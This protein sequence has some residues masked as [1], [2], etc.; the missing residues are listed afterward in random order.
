MALNSQRSD[1][2]SSVRTTEAEYRLLVSSIKAEIS[3]KPPSKCFIYK[4]PAKLCTRRDADAYTYVPRVISIGPYHH[5]GDAFK[6]SEEH[7]RCYLQDLVNRS[8]TSI[9]DFVKSIIDVED[10]VRDC[11]EES[12]KGWRSDKFVKMMVFDGCF[13]LELLYKFKDQKKESDGVVSVDRNCNI[14]DNTYRDGELKTPPNHI[15]DPVLGSTWRIY[16]IRKDLVLLENQLPFIVLEKLFELTKSSSPDN[17]S[18]DK[19][20]TTFFSPI[21]P[22]VQEVK[23]ES[24]INGNHILDLLRNH[25][26]PQSPPERVGD[27]AL[28]EHT[29]SA[30]DLKNAGVK[31]KKKDSNGGLLD[32]TFASPTCG[33]WWR[34]C[35]MGTLEIPPFAF[36]ESWTVL[37]P[38]LIA[39]E[40][41]RRDYTDQITSYVILMDSLINSGN[42]VKILR[43]KRIIDRLFHEDDKVAIDI[44]NLSKG[45]V[46]DRFYY[47]F[48]CSEVNAYC[49][50]RRHRWR[51]NLMRDY[52]NTPWS[53]IKFLAAVIL[54]GLTAIQTAYSIKSYLPH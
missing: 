6:L 50:K 19:L 46:A 38:N 26:L 14:N 41:C 4:V 49:R 28:W 31:F 22:Y 16:S 9:D 27:Y 21:L 45:V 36:G 7:K 13:I 30:T 33:G 24:Q 15:S 48:L 51:A 8:S 54:L 35:T 43:R 44:S 18:L 3:P 37:F 23:T 1:I 5:G 12:V 10:L 20:V 2:E 53:V 40:Q 32:I 42:D 39:L 17:Y 11:Y 25:L 29:Q 34:S 47:D 52:F